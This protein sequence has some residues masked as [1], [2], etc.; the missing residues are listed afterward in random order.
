[1]PDVFNPRGP[2]SGGSFADAVDA[3]HAATVD[4][5]AI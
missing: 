5:P 2:A 1:M 3:F 4:Y